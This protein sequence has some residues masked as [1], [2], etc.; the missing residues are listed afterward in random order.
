MVIQKEPTLLQVLQEL[1]L[2]L[3]TLQMLQID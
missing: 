2:L 3:T 1:K